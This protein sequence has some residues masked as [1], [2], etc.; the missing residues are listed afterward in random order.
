MKSFAKALTGITVTILILFAYT[1]Y[2][3]NLR[4]SLSAISYQPASERAQAF[5]NI[6]AAAKRG[7]AGITVFADDLNGDISEYQ[8]VTLEYTISNIGFL[9][10]EFI[11]L[12]VAP[13]S[14]DVLQ[15][16]GSSEDIAGLTRSVTSAVILTR[17]VGNT[18]DYYAAVSYYI[19]GRQH[20]VRSR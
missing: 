10:A 1:L 12:R 5:E 3:T 20:E 4:V 9:P 18:N 15:I 7:D 8:F 13:N 14:G 19:L 11:E 2:G 6:M 16:D 17:R